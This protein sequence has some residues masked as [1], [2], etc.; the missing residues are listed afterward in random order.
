VCLKVKQWPPKANSL[1][2]CSFFFHCSIFS[3]KQRNNIPICPAPAAR[4]LHNTFDCCLRLSVNC[5]VCSP[6][7]ISMKPSTSSNTLLHMD[8]F[9]LFSLC[10]TMPASCLSM[11]LPVFLLLP[12]VICPDWLLPCRLHLSSCQWASNDTPIRLTGDGG[13]SACSDN[14]FYYHAGAAKIGRAAQPQQ[15]RHNTGSTRALRCLLRE[16]AHKQRG[17]INAIGG[18]VMRTAL[19]GF[20]FLCIVLAVMHRF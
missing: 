4:P 2:P 12:L 19:H 3:P 8:Q 20:F 6:K 18:W 9:L 5:C 16:G 17:G 7:M 14:F 15:P 10:A 1:F 13:A 11:T